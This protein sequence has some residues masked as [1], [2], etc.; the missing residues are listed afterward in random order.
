ME[1][2]EKFLLQELLAGR[3]APFYWLYVVAGLIIPAILMLLPW[4]R[5]VKGIITAAILVNIAIFAK[6]FPVLS[7][8]EIKEQMGSKVAR[9]GAVPAKLPGEP[10]RA[11]SVKR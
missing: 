8:W 9:E 10:V 4:T 2:S 1:E 3:Y 5:N 11:S 7:I 6:I